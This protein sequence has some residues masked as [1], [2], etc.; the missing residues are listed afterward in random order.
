VRVIDSDGSQLGILNSQEAIRMAKEQGLDLVEVS[1]NAKPPV[2]KIM[3]FGKYKY[4]MS[5]REAKARKTQHR[6]TVKEV[7]FRPK[8]DDHDFDFK[9]NHA[10]EFLEGNDKVKFTV[11]FRGREVAHAELGKELLD[12]AAGQLEDIGQV[13]AAPRMEGRTMT[14]YMSPRKDRPKTKGEAAGDAGEGKQAS[15]AEGA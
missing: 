5:K 4:E 11:M 14:M 12:R 2:C 8:I 3:D 6:I 7:K 9:V 10:R 15:P 1:P 13:E